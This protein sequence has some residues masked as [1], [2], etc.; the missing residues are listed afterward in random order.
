VAEPRYVFRP[1]TEPFEPTLDDDTL[2]D[3][4]V[5]L[6]LSLPRSYVDLC[7][8]HNGG[9]LALTAFPSPVPTSWASDHVAV[10]S[11]AAIGRTSPNSLCGQFGHRFWVEEWGYP[12]IG[13][14]F[15]D[16]PS[17]GH[18]MLALDYRAG[19]VPTV[20]HVDQELGY[21]VTPLAAS[22]A[23]FIADLQLDDNFS[24]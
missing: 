13:V 3:V 22:V 23:E 10:T 18:D 21:V 8:R 9:P 11:V 16:C 19:P 6:G 17:A 4:E 7:R 2:R 20:V 1:G 12:D 5:E 15:A 14:Y 24:S